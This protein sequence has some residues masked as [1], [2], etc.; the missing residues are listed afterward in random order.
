MLPDVLC[1]R[2]TGSVPSC[3]NLFCLHDLFGRAGKTVLIFSC[4]AG[5]VDLDSFQAVGFHPQAQLFMNFPDTV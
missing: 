5:D 4:S 2:G 3:E 1:G